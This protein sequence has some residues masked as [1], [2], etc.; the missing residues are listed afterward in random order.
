MCHPGLLSFFRSFLNKTS[1][2]FLKQISLNNI[3]KEKVLGFEPTT[4]RL[5][6]STHNHYFRAPAHKSDFFMFHLQIVNTV[7]ENE[8]NFL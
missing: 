3:H 7:E 4:F 2:Q 5:Q 1:I 8:L 6:V